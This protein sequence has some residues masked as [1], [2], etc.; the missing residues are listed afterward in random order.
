MYFSIIYISAFIADLIIG[1]PR[2]LPHPVVGIGKIIQITEN[3]V[4]RLL[5]RTYFSGIIGWCCVI[6]VVIAICSATMLTAKSINTLFF[7][8]VVIFLLYSGLAMKDLARHSYSVK[9]AMD[10]NEDLSE[11]RQKLSFFVGRE[12]NGLDFKE[13]IRASVESVAENLVD[14]VTSPIFWGILLSCFGND[15][16]QSCVFAVSG[17]FFYKSVNTMDSMWGYKNTKYFKMGWASAKADDVLNFFPARL[18]GIIIV[19]SC[20]LLRYNWRESGRIYF[21]DRLNSTSP[22]AAH[23][24]AAFAGGLNVQLGG[25][26]IYHGKIVDKP[27]IG[28]NID[29][30]ESVHII[31]ANRLMYTSSIV[32]LLGALCIRWIVKTI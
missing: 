16:Q 15:L 27:T 17:L 7:Y 12:T 8:S 11:A 30:L 4:T 32:F 21:R 14:G 1:D 26:N 22:N 9:K 13:I 20:F 19:F 31:K 18:T 29:E 6:A 10:E 25:A 28:E 23:A 5:K 2:C 24:E 3:A